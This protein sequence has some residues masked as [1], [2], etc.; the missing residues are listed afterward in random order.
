MAFSASRPPKDL[1]KMIKKRHP[2]ATINEIRQFI[3]IWNS[4]FDKTNSEAAAYSQAWGTLNRNKKL[5]SSHRKTDPDQTIK[6]VKKYNRKHKIKPPK[7]KKT[8][9]S[10]L[11]FNLVKV[12]NDLDYKG[13]YQEASDLDLI[14]NSILHSK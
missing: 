14:I 6:N 9:K 1:K 4:V 11:I 7:K 8:K 10:F 3:H 13:C 5:K 12:A 2:D